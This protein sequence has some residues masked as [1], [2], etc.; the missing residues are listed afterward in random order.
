MA[1]DKAAPVEEQELD[2]D[3]S[4]DES[5]VPS[6]LDVNFEE[7]P[8]IEVMPAGEYLLKCAGIKLKRQ[9]KE[10]HDPM[11]Q[12]TL[13]FVEHPNGKTFWHYQMFPGETRDADYN[14]GRLNDIRELARAFGVDYSQ[15]INWEDFDGQE[16]WAVV[17]VEESAEYGPSNRIVSWTAA[18]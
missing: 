16:A 8:E 13:K 12:I 1:K 3:L 14:L 2:V 6:F 15:G 17:S 10:P 18:K 9:K 7:V 4:F 11:A 5:D